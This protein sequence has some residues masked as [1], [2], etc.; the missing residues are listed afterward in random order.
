MQTGKTVAQNEKPQKQPDGQRRAEAR[1]L[2]A[3]AGLVY[4]SFQGIVTLQYDAMKNR[5]RAFCPNSVTE[6]ENLFGNFW[7][8]KAITRACLFNKLER[9][10]QKTCLDSV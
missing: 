9:E 2:Q 4:V 1:H 3:A 10:Q 5:G 8:L 6:I 7:T